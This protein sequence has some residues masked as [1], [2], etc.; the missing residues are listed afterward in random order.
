MYDTVGYARS[1]LEGTIIRYGDEPIMV[2]G[3]RGVGRTIYVIGTILSNNQTIDIPL[4][5]CNLTPVPLGYINMGE[6]AF[7]TMRMPMRRDWRQGLRFLNLID[8][9]GRQFNG[10]GYESLVNTIKGVYPSF[11][12]AVEDTVD[13]IS[14]AFHRDFAIKN[15]GNILYKGL[16]D[17]AKWDRESG[18]FSIT[19]EWVRESLD[20][21]VGA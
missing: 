11:T 21:A 20:E 8:V 3:V 9:E 16:V 6:R 19:K 15:N 18:T 4:K 7:Y 2:Q 5:D 10:A 13:N 12:E 17:V 1:R 14:R